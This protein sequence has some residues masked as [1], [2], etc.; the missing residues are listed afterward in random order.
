MTD[1]VQAPSY[2]ILVSEITEK[3]NQ[4]Q[5]I[6]NQLDGANGKVERDE[7]ETRKIINNHAYSFLT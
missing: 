5:P 3:Q 7:G 1:V 4:K 2:E 6:Y